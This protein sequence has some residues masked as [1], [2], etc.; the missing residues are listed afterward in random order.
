MN[1]SDSS[2]SDDLTSVVLQAAKKPLFKRGVSQTLVV[3]PCDNVNSLTVPHWAVT[4]NPDPFVKCNKRAYNKY[5]FDEQVKILTR[6]ESAM[7]RDNP[8]IVLVKLVFETCPKL[9]QAHYHALYQM[10]MM[11]ISTMD[12]YLSHRLKRTNGPSWRMYVAKPIHDEEGWIQ[13]ITKGDAP[14]KL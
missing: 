13:Y 6:I 4:V 2:L 5:S 3:E 1:N 11:F 8:T 7:R 14:A 9:K 10:P 12:N